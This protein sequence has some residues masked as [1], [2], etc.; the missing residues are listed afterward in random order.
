ML[1]FPAPAVKVHYIWIHDVTFCMSTCSQCGTEFG[2]AMVDG[3]D[4]APCWCTKLPPVVP[5]PAPGAAAGCWCPACLEQH[6]AQR[7]AGAPDTP[8]T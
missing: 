7:D 1:Y 5:L 6:I 3:T 4:G 2:C 8:V